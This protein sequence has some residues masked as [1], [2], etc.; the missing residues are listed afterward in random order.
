MHWWELP[1]RSDHLL[2]SPQAWACFSPRDHILHP[3]LLTGSLLPMRYAESEIGL[4]VKK[5]CFIPGPPAPAPNTSPHLLKTFCS[6]HHLAGWS[7]VYLALH[8]AVLQ[9]Y[10]SHY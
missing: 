10:L 4:H 7:K 6:I 8:L 2:G 1:N 9:N 3:G 5:L